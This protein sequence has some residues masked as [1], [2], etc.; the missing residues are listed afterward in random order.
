MGCGGAPHFAPPLPNHK[1]KNRKY[2]IFAHL[3]RFRTRF[4]KELEG[5]DTKQKALKGRMRVI[6]Q[7]YTWDN[8]TCLEVHLGYFSCLDMK[9]LD[10]QNM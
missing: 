9:Y 6:T 8:L 5:C 4:V 1:R 3:T 7:P 2:V 10:S